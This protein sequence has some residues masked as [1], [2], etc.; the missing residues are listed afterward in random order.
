[1]SDWLH[2][3]HAPPT[4]IARLRSFALL[5]REASRLSAEERFPVSE[6][7]EFSLTQAISGFDFVVVE[8]LSEG[9]EACAYPDGCLENPDGPFIKLT[10]SV[11]EGACWGRGR[12]RLTILHECAHVLLH[13]GI[14]V[15]HRG[16]TGVALRPFE[17]SEWQANQLAAEL[18]MPVPSF[19]RFESLDEYREAMGVS[20][21]AA[22][23][24]LTGLLSR[25]EIIRPKWAD[26][27]NQ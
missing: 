8:K 12:D 20:W 6:F 15:H 11:Y 14:A 5:I 23:V 16:P 13:R 4:S 3:V 26:E 9:N 24:R 19:G 22:Q 21:Q 27:V 10:N 2:G 1:M 17:N 7:L 18:L 25:N